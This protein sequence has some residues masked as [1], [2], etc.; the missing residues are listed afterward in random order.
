MNRF[1]PKLSGFILLL[2]LVVGAAYVAITS[3]INKDYAAEVNQRLY[4]GIADHTVAVV[5]PLV[6]GQVDTTQI[7]DIMHSMMV[8]NP[9]VEVYLLQPDGEIITYV[10]PNKRVRLE[11]VDL[12]PIQAFL[13]G[14]AAG[15]RPFVKGDDPRH[16]E[17][18]NIFSAAE[19][20]DTTGTLEGYVYII[21]S[22]E[23][24][25]AV[26]AQLFGGYMA[27]QG[28]LL[29]FLSLLA[30]F[31]VGLI[32][33]RYLT[34][35]LRRI[36]STIE[37]LREGDYAAR[38]AVDD[39]SEF[40][41]V[42]ATF[43]DMAD[44]LNAHIEEMK[45]VDRLRRELIANISHDLR[46]PLA[47]IQGFVETLQMKQDRMPPA[48]QQQYLQT[49]YN[50]T[51]RLGR[52][53][54]QLFDYSKLEARQIEPR[55]EA[56]N[57]GELAQDVVHKFGVLAKKQQV[58]VIVDLPPQLPYIFADL[59]LVE[60]VLDNLM[61][62]ALKFTPAGGTIG[63]QMRPTEDTVEIQVSDTGPGIPEADLPFVFDRYRKG[64]RA[65]SG[66]NMGAGLG[67]AIVKKILE[68]HNQGIQIRSRLREGTS[69]VFH[70]PVIPSTT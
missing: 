46:T 64:A 25:Q 51:D 10:A 28:M 39:R 8:I 20:R 56:F 69:F 4:G 68:L 30:A 58:D 48:Q 27:R 52:L 55:R 41:P 29:F 26:T 44:Q 3:Y 36:A 7:Q 13:Q 17:Q 49:I 63:L 38:I 42:A 11:R 50:G 60:R 18:P 33:L 6:D 61:D 15:E 2:F 31:V 45:S 12:R 40:T 67:L 24:E 19:I 54:A 23:E 14:G 5:K 62:N 16:P 57:V 34:R 21:Q 35:Q 9:S 32:G 59:G 66:I 22:G 1:F 53:I 70:L 43:N 65:G 47:I 37:R